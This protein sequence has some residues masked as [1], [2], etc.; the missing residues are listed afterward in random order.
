M[1]SMEL[2]ADWPRPIRPGGGRVAAFLAGSAAIGSLLIA[3]LV[4]LADL[5]DEADDR[6]GFDEDPEE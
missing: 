1:R 5:D 6:S 3:L 2:T 4:V